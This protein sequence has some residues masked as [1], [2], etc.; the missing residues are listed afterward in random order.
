LP[1]PSNDEAIAE[2]M[3]LDK[4]AKE[5][6]IVISDRIVNDII[7][8]LTANRLSKEQIAELINRMSYGQLRLTQTLLFDAL[9]AELAARDVK[10]ILLQPY[11]RRGDQMAVMARFRGAPPADRWD[12]FCR[13]NR[14]V[15]AEVLPVS[16]ET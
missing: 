1:L 12:Y 11:N 2:A 14:K 6:G 9:R 13:L 4:K 8:G 5:L 15:T 3:L 7:Y 16:V 10:E